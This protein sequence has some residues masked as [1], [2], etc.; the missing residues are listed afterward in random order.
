MQI[1]TTIASWNIFS[2]WRLACS[3]EDIHA[4][5]MDVDLWAQ[6]S[7]DTFGKDSFENL[8]VT[9]IKV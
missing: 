8:T 9:V 4:L 5:W 7:K 2:C 1:K 6:E 3:F